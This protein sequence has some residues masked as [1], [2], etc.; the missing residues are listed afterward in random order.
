M[1]ILFIGDFSIQSKA[2]EHSSLSFSDLPGVK[3]TYPEKGQSAKVG[4]NLEIIG[5]SAYNPDHTCHVSVIINDVKPYQETIPTGTK[6]KNDFSTWEYV[7]DSDYTTINKG[8]NKITARL[9]CSDDRGEDLR[10]WYS[11]NVIGQEETE[12][13]STKMLAM[14]ATIQT[15]STATPTTINIDRNVFMEI[16]N[17]RIENNI[18]VIRD[19]IEDSIMS[20]Y[21]RIS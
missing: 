8:D 1:N 4:G 3:I 14:P 5:T 20:F 21:A 17:N 12:N 9:L 7:T 15:R 19:A 13:L 6:T 16:V 11:V 10:K 2:S 18:E